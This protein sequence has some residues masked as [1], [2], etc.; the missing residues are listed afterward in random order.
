MMIPQ[1]LNLRGLLLLGALALGACGGVAPAGQD[2]VEPP[3]YSSGGPPGFFA[4]GADAPF[5]TAYRGTRLVELYY[6]AQAPLVYREDVG[7]DGLGK[8]S[9]ETTNVVVSSNANVNLFMLLQTQRQIHI[10]RHRDFRIRDLGLFLANYD[11]SVDANTSTV[12]GVACAHVQIQPKVSAT[13]RYEVDIDPSTGLVLR[14]EEYS[15]ATGNLEARVAFEVYTPDGDVTDM[16]LQDRLFQTSTY[17]ADS[18]AFT[19]ALGFEPLLPILRPGIG[20]Q[21][22][23]QGE[24]L[25]INGEN[26]AKLFLTDGM[27]VCIL[28]HHDTLSGG[29]GIPGGGTSGTTE[30]KG[31]VA[32]LKIGSWSALRGTLKGHDIIMAGRVS[33]L[34]LATVLDSALR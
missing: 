6:D 18:A 25:E 21:L 1:S 16:V 33:E 22:Q 9:V 32:M 34:D 2:T 27:G 8:F 11:Y 13:V 26:W 5:N 31:E 17:V 30:K 24:R 4:L 12:A 29:P 15:L 20:Y 10:Y 23:A 7:S 19:Q 3:L 28:M 14:W